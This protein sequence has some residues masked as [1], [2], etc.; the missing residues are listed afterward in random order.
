[1][2][3]GVQGSGKT[4][5]CAKLAAMLKKK[6]KRPLL[7]AADLE[8]PAAIEQ[9][10]TLGR[11][12]GVPVVSDGKDPVKVAKAA[13]KEAERQDADVVI[14]DTAGRLHVDDEMMKQARRIKRRRRSRITSSW[15]ATR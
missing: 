3:A 13:L 5:A 15:R 12:I 1:M 14:I 6:G 11:E 4:T 10:R 2:M 8:R 7:V 9:L